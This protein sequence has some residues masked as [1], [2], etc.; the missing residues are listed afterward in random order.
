MRLK[1]TPQEQE[2]SLKRRKVY[3]KN[4]YRNYY[5]KNKEKLKEYQKKYYHEIRLRSKAE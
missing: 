2:G 3:A 4:Y 1:L 5:Q